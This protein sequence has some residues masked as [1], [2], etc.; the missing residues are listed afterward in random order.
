MAYLIFGWIRISREQLD[1]THD[2]PGC[3]ETTLQCMVLRERML[4]GMRVIGR[5]DAFD[6]R[7]VTARRL[8]REHVAG[9]D[10][11]PVQENSTRSA[12]RGVTAH[13]RPGQPE[14][15]PQQM[16]QQ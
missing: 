16:H 5:G 3:A 11:V 8:H 13:M 7:D 9:F 15:I 10:G 4:D 1:A 14:L 2:K 6:C 12:L